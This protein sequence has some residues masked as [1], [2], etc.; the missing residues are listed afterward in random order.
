MDIDH[1]GRVQ[2]Q[3]VNKP[4]IEIVQ[5]LPQESKPDPFVSHQPKEP[6]KGYYAQLAHDRF[7]LN[8]KLTN[9]FSSLEKVI[10]FSLGAYGISGGGVKV[11]HR[12]LSLVDSS[13][14]MRNRL[15]GIGGLGI[16]LGVASIADHTVFKH[17][18]L[19]NASAI[20][21]M[22]AAPLVAWRVPGNIFIKAG[23]V[24]AVALLG[25]IIDHLNQPKYVYDPSRQ[26]NLEQNK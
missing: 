11:A 23:A 19:G 24:A 8:D 16:G 2:Q 15:V 12:R 18:T 20:S 22:I 9:V 10:G 4:R 26:M 17:D 25:K 5:R 1:S 14:P 13:V 21:D 6:Y 7:E 3:Y